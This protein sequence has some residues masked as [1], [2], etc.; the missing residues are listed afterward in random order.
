MAFF[1]FLLLLS[2]NLSMVLSYNSL[3]GFHEDKNFIKFVIKES[4]GK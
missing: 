2:E 3:L 4:S 1:D